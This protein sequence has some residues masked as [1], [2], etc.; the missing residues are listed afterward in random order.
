LYQLSEAIIYLS[1][2]DKASVDGDLCALEI[3]LD[4]PVK[5][6]PDYLFLAFTTIEHA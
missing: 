5:L 3:N 4:G 2:L 6:R 1:K